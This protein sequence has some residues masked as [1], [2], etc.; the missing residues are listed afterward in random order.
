MRR[1]ACSV[2]QSADHAANG[3]VLPADIIFD[4]EIPSLRLK[5]RARAR[6]TALRSVDYGDVLAVR[7][8]DLDKPNVRKDVKPSSAGAH[9]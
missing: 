6:R 7:I 5:G 3:A 2:E 9:P 4:L 8:N 1:F